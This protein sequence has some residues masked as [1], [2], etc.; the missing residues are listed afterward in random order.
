MQPCVSAKQFAAD[1]LC[2]FSGV[3]ASFGHVP[4]KQSSMKDK[5]TKLREEHLHYRHLHEQAGK[6]F[7]GLSK[8]KFY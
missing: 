2:N 8:H 1:A 3:D 4:A 6:T 5:H 7:F